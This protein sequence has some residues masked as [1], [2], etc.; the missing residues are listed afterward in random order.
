[1]SR[2]ILRRLRGVAGTMLTW[3][4]G[5]GLLGAVGGAGVWLA[6]RLVN[7]DAMHVP[8][9][10]LGL[11]IAGAIAGAV[12]GLA[13]ALSLAVAERRR[14]FDEL[15]AW[16]TGA[17][18]AASALAMGWLI[19][20]DPTFAAICGTVGFG[21]AATSLVVARRALAPAESADALLLPPRV[22]VRRP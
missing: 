6:V 3:S 14:S 5:G 18:G 13:F 9:V 15:R 1:M 12:S 8:S 17:L 20:R 16:R 21:G 2:L 4:V 19:S 10:V 7:G 11:G 22:P